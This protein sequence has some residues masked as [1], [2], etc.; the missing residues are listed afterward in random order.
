MPSKLI[1]SYNPS[2]LNVRVSSNIIHCFHRPKGRKWISIDTQKCLA[3]FNIH[4]KLFNMLNKVGTNDILFLFIPLSLS[5]CMCVCVYIY[6][7]YIYILYIYNSHKAIISLTRNFSDMA[8]KIKKRERCPLLPLL[9]NI[10]LQILANESS[11]L[12]LKN[13]KIRSEK[14]S[15]WRFFYIMFSRK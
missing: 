10:V 5:L 3:K 12:N 4:L 2:W 6:I 8:T 15:L 14:T 1:Y 9:F 7:I 11:Q 13:R